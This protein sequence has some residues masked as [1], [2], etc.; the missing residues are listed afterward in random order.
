[1][2]A[3]SLPL[4]QTTNNE[5]PSTTLS[6]THFQFKQFTIQQDR[7]ALKVGTDGVLLG[8]WTNYAGADRILDIGTGTGLLALIAAQR[9]SR[10]IIDAIEIDDASAQQAKEN[11]EASPW[12]DRVRVHRMD[13]RRMNA[14]ERY[15]LIICNPPFYAGEMDSPDERKG[16]AKHGGELIFAELIAAV[17]RLLA[18]EGRFAVIVPL[19]RESEF[20]SEASRIGLHLSKRCAVRYLASKS[21]KRL[22]FELK[23]GEVVTEQEEITVEECGPF[24]Y[25]ARYCELL[26]D[27]MLKF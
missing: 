10:A 8:G 13:V 23:R 11:V 15:D 9:N 22:L 6:N 12:G 7:C 14:S 20:T 24:D 25:S 1:M 18:E 3:R 27:L 21:P 5:Q 19:N 16:L 17:D 4:G 2:P 26:R